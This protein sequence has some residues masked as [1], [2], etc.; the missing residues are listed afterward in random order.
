MIDLEKAVKDAGGYA[1]V[2]KLIGTTKQVVWSWVNVYKRVPAKR[3]MA[4]EKAVGQPRHLIR[5]DI[6]PADRE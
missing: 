2:A 6:Y 1:K 3:T 5:P 4:F